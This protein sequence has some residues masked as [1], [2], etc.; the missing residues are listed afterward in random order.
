MIILII[1]GVV[2]IIGLAAGI[3]CLIKFHGK[4]R[5]VSVMPFGVSLVCFLLILLIFASLSHFGKAPRDGGQVDFPSSTE[6]I[7]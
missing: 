4:R 1:V 6:Q 3:V 5:V 7:E 2:G